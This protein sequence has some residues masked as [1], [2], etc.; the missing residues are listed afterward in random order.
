LLGAAH[1]TALL[2]TKA[3]RTDPTRDALD[4]G[5]FEI[6]EMARIGREWAL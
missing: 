4:I 3:R 1:G 2:C 5:F 6:R